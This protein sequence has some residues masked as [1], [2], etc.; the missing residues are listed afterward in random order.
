M[1]IAASDA[2]SHLQRAIASSSVSLLVA[3]L[4]AIDAA[5]ASHPTLCDAH[6]QVAAL[7]TEANELVA[8]LFEDG[9]SLN[10]GDG[11]INRAVASGLARESDHREQRDESAV[12]GPSLRSEAISTTT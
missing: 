11:D 4:S 12:F 9:A 3:T 2:T 8:A 10:D 7:R 5:V 1:A 6:P